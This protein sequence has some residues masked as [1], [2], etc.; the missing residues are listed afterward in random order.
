MI[1]E[2]IEIKVVP[3]SR[4]ERRNDRSDLLVSQHLVKALLFN[5]ERLSPKGKNGLKL[6]DAR[7]L[8]SSPRRV[9]LDNEQ[10]IFFRASFPSKRQVFPTS[11]KESMLFLARGVL[12]C[13]PGRDAHARRVLRLFDDLVKDFFVFRLSDQSTQPLIDDSLHG[14]AWPIRISIEFGLGLSFE[15]YILHLDGQDRGQPLAEIIAGKIGVFIF[16][17]LGVARIVVQNARDPPRNPVS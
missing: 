8:C 15:L 2:L 11:C 3:D 6:S 4:A 16:E 13:L 12:L 7:L 1:I 10:L 17:H 14:R 9:S 5:V